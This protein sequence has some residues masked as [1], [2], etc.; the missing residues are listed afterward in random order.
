MVIPERFRLEIL[1]HLARLDCRD[2]YYGGL[3]AP[4]IL[5]ISGPPGIGKSY[6]T[7]QCLREAGSQVK[8]L[9]TSALG[10]SFEAEPVKLLEETLQDL[11]EE[12]EEGHG[13][14][15]LIIDDMDMS[16]GVLSD[17][18]YTVNTQ[19]TTGWLMAKADRVYE[20]SFSVSDPAIIVTGN[21]FSGVHRPLLR[22]G[23]ARLFEYTP[24]PEESCA[25]L[26]PIFE[27]HVDGSPEELVRRFPRACIADFLEAISA[28]RDRWIEGL[29]SSGID[30]RTCGDEAPRISV[31]EAAAALTIEK[32]V[33]AI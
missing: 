13:R 20:P 23:R 32:L 3:S 12:W 4:R 29:I 11:R 24:T 15:A 18:S 26:L 2:A 9:D 5:C 33:E 17:R 1:K 8:H 21:D 16:L 27:R 22:N 31:D 19:L 25:V 30:P 10:G 6:Q 28:L 14:P 7:A